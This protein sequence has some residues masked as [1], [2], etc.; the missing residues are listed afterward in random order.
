MLETFLAYIPYEIIHF[1][2]GCA[3]LPCLGYVVFVILTL[4]KA[5][6]DSKSDPTN[7]SGGHYVSER[8][9]PRHY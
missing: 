4:D 1:H 9:P 3:I 5:V 2:L 6:W 7:S 8:W